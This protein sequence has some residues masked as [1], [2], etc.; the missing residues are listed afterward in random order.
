MYSNAW[1]DTFATTVPAAILAWKLDAIADLLPREEYGRVLDGPHDDGRKT[2][3]ARRRHGGMCR[4][5][6]R[7]R[8]WYFVAA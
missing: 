2:R 3:S 6:I 8:G 7:Q 1:F 4:I 5:G